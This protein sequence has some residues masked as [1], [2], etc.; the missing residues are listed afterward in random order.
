MSTPVDLFAPA[1]SGADPF[2]V[3]PFALN[4]GVDSRPAGVMATALDVPLADAVRRAVAWA[5]AQLA[6]G[7]SH[8]APWLTAPA[9]RSALTA[10]A[11]V[12]CGACVIKTVA[13]LASTVTTLAAIAAVVGLGFRMARG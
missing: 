12:V 5:W 3:D 11:V 9:G 6:L 2:A 4:Q 7:F 1:P 8:A 10:V 13:S